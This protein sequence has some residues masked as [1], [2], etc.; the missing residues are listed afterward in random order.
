LIPESTQG[1]PL[2]MQPQTLGVPPPPQVAGAAQL[3]GQ[4]PLQPFGPPH[5][6]VQSDV[7]LQLE[8]L[9]LAPSPSAVWQDCA[10]QLHKV[11]TQLWPDPV[12][13][14]AQE[15]GFPQLSTPMPQAK[16]S[17]AQLLGVQPHLLAVPLPPQV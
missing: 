7:Q 5:R 1:L 15:I 14:S 9:Q 17:A 4:V 12:Q 11:P 10:V 13:E 16:P 6:P 3:S 2:E 8:P